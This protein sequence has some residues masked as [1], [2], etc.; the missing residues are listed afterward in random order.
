MKRTVE[1]GDAADDPDAILDAPPRSG[2]GGSGVDGD[3]SAPPVRLHDQ[4]PPGWLDGVRAQMQDSSSFQRR[5]AL[6]SI[7]AHAMPP[8]RAGGSG[9]QSVHKA[10]FRA[11]SSLLADPGLQVREAAQETLARL[12][13]A[14]PQGRA[15]CVKYAGL[16]LSTTEPVRVRLFLIQ[17][18]KLFVSDA[19]ALVHARSGSGEPR[20]DSTVGEDAGAQRYGWFEGARAAAIEALKRYVEA[21][22]TAS[23]HKVFQHAEHGVLVE[24]TDTADGQPCELFEAATGRLVWTRARFLKSFFLRVSKA[25][26][27]ASLAPAH[28]AEDSQYGAFDRLSEAL[29]SYRALVRDARDCHYSEEA[30]LQAQDGILYFEHLSTKTHELARLAHAV[31]QPLKT[32]NVHGKTGKTVER[33]ERLRHGEEDREA[34]VMNVRLLGYSGVF[35]SSSL[36]PPSGGAQ[37]HASLDWDVTVGKRAVGGAGDGVG[38]TGRDSKL[39]AAPDK[40]DEFAARSSATPGVASTVVKQG[41]LGLGTVGGGPPD[42]IDRLIGLVALGGVSHAGGGGQDE[43]GE[44]S[45]DKGRGARAEGKQVG[46]RREDWV[47]QREARNSLLRLQSNALAKVGC[48]DV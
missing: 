37:V 42:T 4:G 38:A 1:G 14:S 10:V 44:K 47:V 3:D 29:T 19:L 13:A 11:A 40:G 48:T 8:A 16:L 12:A 23:H 46:V 41:A 30:L 6:A 22:Q 26:E 35:A 34:R 17:T 36:P 24:K 18:L 33:D 45:E 15:W 32:S 39:Q 28:D 20:A 2:D 9:A 27:E 31:T 7:E 21:E 25:R 5:D 43:G